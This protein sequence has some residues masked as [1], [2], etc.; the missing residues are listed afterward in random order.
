[1]S[2]PVTTRLS[3]YL[4][5]IYQ[6]D[7]YLKRYVMAFEKILLGLDDGVSLPKTEGSTPV[8]PEAG[9]ETSIGQLATLFDPQETPE[10]FLEWLSSWVAFTLRQH[11]EPQIQRQFIANVV[12][13]YRYRGTKTNL[14]E[15]LKIFVQGKP[16]I[17]EA[18]VAELQIGVNSTLGVDTYLE[19]GPHHFFTVE[20]T[21]PERLDND[22]EALDQQIAI[23]RALIELEKPAHTTYDLIPVF[24]GTLQIGVR[25]TIGENTLL[26]NIPDPEG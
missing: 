24:P 9:L 18:A 15:L 20:L 22:P 25:S 4:P 19:G 7:E 14:E 1:M 6:G 8:F 23:T 21:L 5:N 17:T 10:E 13:R 26:G 12:K 11:I 2:D 16:K 3:D